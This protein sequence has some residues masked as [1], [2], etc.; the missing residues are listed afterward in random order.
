VC[1]YVHPSVIADL[2]ASSAYLP[3]RTQQVVHGD[4]GAALR[5]LSP[6]SVD[7][8]VAA[9]VSTRLVYSS[10]PCQMLLCFVSLSNF[11]SLQMQCTYLFLTLFPTSCV[12]TILLRTFIVSPSPLVNFLSFTSPLPSG[13]VLPRGFEA[14]ILGSV[15]G[16]FPQRL[17]CVHRGSLAGCDFTVFIAAAIAFTSRSY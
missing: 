4:I 9:D 17:L 12:C 16:A 14:H 6:K 8:I 13:V 10:L 5:D 15:F 7:L 11:L 2:P 3:M 1:T